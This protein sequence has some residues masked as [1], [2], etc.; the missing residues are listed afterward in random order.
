MFFFLKSGPN[1]NCHGYQTVKIS[2]IQEV[3]VTQT[4]IT[5]SCRIEDLL[6]YSNLE[7]QVITNQGKVIFVAACF[8]ALLGLDSRKLLRTSVHLPSTI[9]Y[10]R[11]T[12]HL[13]VS[14]SK[15]KNGDLKAPTSHPGHRPGI[16]LQQ[17]SSSLQWLRSS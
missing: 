17:V 5:S 9:I 3:S 13:Q 16:K 1:P 7:A 2:A 6:I 10:L 15:V 4:K 8:Y 12:H 14:K 11:F